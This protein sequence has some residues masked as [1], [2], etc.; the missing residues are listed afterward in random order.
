MVLIGG[1]LCFV[2][3]R[4]PGTTLFIFSTLAVCLTQMFLLYIY[5]LP[6]F[7]AVWTVP[8]V[9]FVTLG[10]GLGMGYGAAKWPKIGVMIMGFCLGSLLGFGIYYA[11]M[12]SSVSTTTAKILTITGVAIFTAI[13]YI[14][15]FDY[16]VIVTSAIFGAYIFV[17][18][19][20][21]FTGGYVDEY[22][23]ILA[24]QN[25]ELGDVQWTQIFFWVL[26]GLLALVSVNMQLKDRSSH[27]EA[28]AYKK[29]NHAQFE[30][31]RSMRERITRLGGSKDYD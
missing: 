16:M 11:F 26:M 13:L 27:L 28:Y 14:I 19:I 23:I 6:N 21:M 9:F 24:S 3:G 5:I 22:T 20:S 4:F 31:Y 30:N 8:I 15:L 1:Y 17:R 25:S 29:N 12:E 7:A 10:M 2:G 18:G